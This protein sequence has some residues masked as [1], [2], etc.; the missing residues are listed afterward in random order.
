[1]A[2]MA[3]EDSNYGTMSTDKLNRLLE[4]IG[5]NGPSLGPA[6]QAAKA[7]IEAILAARTKVVADGYSAQEVV[8]DH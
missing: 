2:G 7:E 4:Q 6:Q 8:A 3:N 5:R 1:M